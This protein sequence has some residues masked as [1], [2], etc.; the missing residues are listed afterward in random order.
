MSK[1]YYQII[2]SAFEC[3]KCGSRFNRPNFVNNCV[4]CGSNFNY[5]NSNYQKIFSDKI[6]DKINKELTT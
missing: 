2:G 4:K 6:P 1:R 3:N 5:K